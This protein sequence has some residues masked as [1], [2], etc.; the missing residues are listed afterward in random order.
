MREPIIYTAYTA[1]NE[2]RRM[3]IDSVLRGA[4]LIGGPG[5]DFNRL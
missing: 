4:G 1:E 3:M 2:R 5:G